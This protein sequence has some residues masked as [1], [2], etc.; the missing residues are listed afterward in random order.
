MK[1]WMTLPLLL[2]LASCSV[3]H[4]AVDLST[5]Q[6]KQVP[7]GTVIEGDG[8]EVKTPDSG[9]YLKLD[10]P[11]RGGI[12]FR[13][14]QPVRDGKAYFVTPFESSAPTPALAMNEWNRRPERKGLKAYP[15][16]RSNTMIEGRPAHEAVVD[17]PVSDDK[18]NIAVI[19][20]VKRATDYLILTRGENYHSSEIKPAQLELCRK[21]LAKLKRSTT[22]SAE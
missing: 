21:G 14:V 13:P 19:L 1:L 8:F 16:E 17:V 15:S 5:R 6:A 11:T 20:V 7:I 22:I 10:Y 18:G 2:V 4:D 3:M 9:L 12:T